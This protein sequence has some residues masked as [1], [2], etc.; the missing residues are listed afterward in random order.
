MAEYWIRWDPTGKKWEYALDG[1]A[2][3]DLVENPTCETI[4]GSAGALIINSDYVTI[5]SVSSYLPN[6]ILANSNADASGSFLVMR[7]LSASPALA[8]N[9]GTI[10]F[11]GR[12]SNLALKNFGQIIG[13]SRAVAAGA[14]LG[15]LLF[16]I[17][18]NGAGIVA[19][20][21]YDDKVLIP[22]RL[23]AVVVGA[24][25]YNSGNV[26]VNSGVLTLM[27]FDSEHHDI[28]GF[29]S[30]PTS[31]LTIPTGLGGKYIFVASCRFEGPTTPVGYR[32]FRLEKN[33]AG[34]AAAANIVKVMSIPAITTTLI[35]TEFTVVTD[36]ITLAAG[37]HI[38]IFAFHNQGAALNIQGGAWGATS[39]I[40]GGLTFSCFR[41]ST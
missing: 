20:D 27:T 29:H 40:N 19:L 12:D 13:I 37:D 24:S 17:Y 16:Y 9:I 32:S 26:A 14:E 35:P 8:D 30:T 4:K 36:E 1:A 15:R 33:S 2:F 41:V 38:E 6:V 21:L 18:N 5:P 11:Q 23:D 25:I 3:A 28:Y 10:S 22:I 39:G 7:K 31:R 34:T